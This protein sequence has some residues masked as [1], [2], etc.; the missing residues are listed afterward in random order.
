MAKEEKMNQRTY[1]NRLGIIGWFY[2]G[3]YWIERYAYILHRIS[4]FALIFYLSLHVFVTGER[5]KGSEAWEAIMG[6]LRTPVFHFLEYLLLIAFIYHAING[7]RLIF[8]EFGVFLGKPAQPK[9]PYVTS[10]HKQR[11]F[12]FILMIIGAIFLIIATIEYFKIGG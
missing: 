2:G 5:A 7:F 8:L 9:Y 4:G 11:P 10:I 1:K 6:F 12:V 3:R